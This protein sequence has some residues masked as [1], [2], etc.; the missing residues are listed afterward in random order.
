MRWMRWVVAL[1]LAIGV[2]GCCSGLWRA[3]A[4]KCAG[5]CLHVGGAPE[6]AVWG[7]T[8][9]LGSSGGFVED[10]KAYGP[11]SPKH[12]GRYEMSD[13]S[14]VVACFCPRRLPR[15]YPDGAWDEGGQDIRV[16]FDEPRGIDLTVWIVQGPFDE[17][18]LIASHAVSWAET[19]WAQERMGLYFSK[20]EYCDATSNDN[21]E[22][23]L[24]FDEATDADIVKSEEDGGIGFRN[25]RINVYY[26]KTVAIHAG[27]TATDGS[28]DALENYS[29]TAAGTDNFVAI[30][31][32]AGNTLLVHELGHCMM[33]D[34]P[35]TGDSKFDETNVMYATSSS[36][37][38]LTEGQIFYS[39]GYAE[40]AVN[41]VY[42][43][44]PPEQQLA[45]TYVPHRDLPLDLRLF[46]D[47]DFPA[48]E[49]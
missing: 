47:G 31:A 42:G 18:R 30:A 11:D 25:C 29:G 48:D 49:P 46:P 22:K 41:S 7:T 33:L 9:D 4:G 19:V 6:G 32:G 28:D 36:R 34:H 20:V 35:P 21:R 16:H 38:Y 13:T 40:S 45:L 37:R 27:T 44:H 17:V 2:T 43:I 15:I 12:L 3:I 23:F 39:H 10:L 24:A 1:L 5:V 26:V 8:L 14:S